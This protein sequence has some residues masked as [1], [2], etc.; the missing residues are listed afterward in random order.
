MLVGGFDREGEQAGTGG[1]E[2]DDARDVRIAL[3]ADRNNTVPAILGRADT[4]CWVS[5]RAA[6]R[7]S[8]RAG[9]APTSGSPDPRY[10]AATEGTGEPP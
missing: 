1:N 3:L 6:G 10:A 4:F 2:A 7:R 8:A 5:S 9:A